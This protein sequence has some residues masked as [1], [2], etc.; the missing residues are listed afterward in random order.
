MKII[1]LTPVEYV[2]NFTKIAKFLFSSY[3]LH[4][5]VHVE[6]NIKE[7]ELLGY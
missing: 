3:V 5:N 6:A 4:G 1:T 7:L 2:A